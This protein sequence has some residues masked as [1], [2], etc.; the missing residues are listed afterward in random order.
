MHPREWSL[1]GVVLLLA[2]AALAFASARAQ[3]PQGP[4]Q[5]IR[6][7]CRSAGFA[8]GAAKSGT[9]LAIDCVNPIMQ[10]KAQRPKAS[11]PLPA[12][13]PQIVAACKTANPSFGQPRAKQSYKS[14]Q[15][16]TPSPAPLT[17]KTPAQPSPGPAK[18]PNIV[19]VVTDDLAWN[20]V[21]YMPHVLQMQRE[22]VTFSNYFVTNSLCCP[23][24]SSILT[25]RYPHS[26]G[27]FRNVGEDGGYQGFRTRDHETSTFAVALSA[28]GYRTAMLVKYLNGYRPLDPVAPGWTSWAVAGGGGYREFNYNLNADGKSV[29]YGGQAADYLTDVLG[30]AAVRFIKESAGTPFFIEIATFAPHAPYIPAP[31]DAEALADVRAPR[32]GAYNAPLDAETPKW[33]QAMRALSETDM[34]NI[35]RDFRKRAQ[36]VLAVDRMIGELQAAVAAIGEDRNTYFLFSSD[37]GHHMGDTV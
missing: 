37:N 9:G 8:P 5:Q 10:G 13:D 7:A 31:R 4:C 24:R 17:Q 32:T 11:K 33:L 21:Q 35:D 28:A 3:A 25:G 1:G 14:N 27:I 16:P 29:H 26:T 19:F 22:G 36:T 12:V 18:R 6:A 15:S 34:A 20:L 2:V 23:S 30:G